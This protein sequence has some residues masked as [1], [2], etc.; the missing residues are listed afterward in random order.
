MKI[1][2]N[3]LHENPLNAEIYGTD[4]PAQLAELVDKIRVSE[5]IKPLIINRK[6]IIISGHRRFK[7]AKI[8]GMKEIE[9]EMINNKDE[10]QE[11]EILLAENFFREKTTLQKVREAEYYRIV[12]ETKAKER[13]NFIGM[14]NLGQISDRANLPELQT[15]G[16]T[17][18]IISEKI[19]MSPR[20][21]DNARKVV[22]KI[23]EEDD[24]E[25]K[26]FLEGTLNN[27]SVNAAT[28]LVDKPMEFIHEVIERTS[29]DTKNVSAVVREI[30][31]SESC[32]NQKPPMG[33]YEVVYI[34]LTES[35]V[36][37]LH[38]MQ[39]GNLIASD[40]VLFIW[41]FPQKLAQAFSLIQRWGF[42]YR[43]SMLLKIDNVN[44]VSSDGA[45]LLIS[46]RGKCAVMGEKKQQK[47]G[48]VKPPE[49]R[50]LIE[51]TYA[52]DKLEILPDGWQIWGRVE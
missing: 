47:S 2:I 29:G 1:D 6:Y 7:T 16:R 39:F 11:L 8:L 14:Q 42:K 40:S 31:S 34:D 25:I 32:V 13:R 21:Y 4:D 35:F 46:T 37:D 51:K 44:E 27:N 24:P 20:S 49:I 50:N 15:T 45:L 41:V 26:A 48:L 17:R 19:G 38:K 36:H 23:D 52:G 3:L 5:Y 22:Q 28:K 10:N 43:N 33:Q 12:E 9:V 30:E 18:D